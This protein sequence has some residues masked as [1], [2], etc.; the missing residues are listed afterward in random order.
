MINPKYSIIIPVYNRPQ[1]VDELLASIVQQT[2][3]NLEVIIV[4]DGSV[5][6]AESVV[7]KYKGELTIRYF[8]KPNSGPGPSRNFGFERAAGDYFV[9]FDSDCIIPPSY[10][11]TVDNFLQLSPLDVWGGPDKGSSDFTEKQ[12][13]M[14]YT[15][16]SIFTTGGIRGG[17]AKDFQPRSFNMGMSKEVY[18]NTGGFQLDRFAEDIEFSI[19]VKKMG[20]KVGLIPQAF[21]YHK[22][23][24]N[25][26]QF[27]KQVSNFG[28]GRVQVGRVHPNAIKLAHWFPA[29]FFIGL[30]LLPLLFLVAPA[31][32]MLGVFGYSLYFSIIALH[33]F[34]TTNSL[35]VSILSVPAAFV[36]LTGYGYGFLKEMV[37]RKKVLKS[38]S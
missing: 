24:T 21:V 29:F 28:A 18:K 6:T 19:R 33:A 30:V 5:T 3:R 15:M 10:L 26:N 17:K 16:A 8:T 36:Q 22:R 20:L 2:V 14:A 31:M 1:E 37:K 4:E 32:G 38:G 23:R 11:A 7:D 25:F 35:H 13:A 27:F 34:A 9:V 12:Q